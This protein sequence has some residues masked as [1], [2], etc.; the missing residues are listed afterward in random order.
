MCVL[1]CPERRL[2][3]EG[4]RERGGV[5]WGGGGEGGR[6]GGREKRMLRCTISPCKHLAL[7]GGAAGCESKGS[8]SEFNFRICFP[9]GP[10]E[11]LA[12]G[13]SD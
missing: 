2:S 12:G 5:G 4:E 7:L 13:K 3:R 11:V 1:S 10:R 9:V 6:E 8:T